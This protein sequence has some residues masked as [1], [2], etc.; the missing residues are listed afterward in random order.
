M[1]ILVTG[2]QGYIGKY[3]VKKLLEQKH[4]VIDYCRE[5]GRSYDKEHIIVTGELYDIPRLLQVLKKYSV[6]RIIHTAGQSHPVVSV[7][8]PLQTVEA[9]INGTIGVLEAARLS[10]IKRVVLFSSEAAYG[11]QPTEHIG[12]DVPLYPRTPY[13]V[14]KAACEMFGRAYNWSYGME[15]ISIR[16][17]QVYGPGHITQ[18]YIR[19]AIKAGLRGEKYV[20]PYGKEYKI[21]LIHVEDIADLS[22]CACFTKTFNDKAVYNGTSGYQPYFEEVLE[23]LKTMIDG[24]EYEIGP[25]GVGRDKQGLFDISDTINDLGYEPKV[26]LEDG[27]KS[28]IEW[29]KNNEY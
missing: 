8:A 18:E 29:L 2:G 19:D 7:E 6:D 15:C 14:T 13:G 21:Q 4:R 20:L 24:F 9:N 3:I 26:S 1:N 23:M 11:N 25:G 28:Y 12:L 22:I 17:G 27:L 10:G 16:C 5:T